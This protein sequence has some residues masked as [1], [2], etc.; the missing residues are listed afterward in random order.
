MQANNQ[1]IHAYTHICVVGILFDMLEGIGLDPT[2]QDIRRD[3]FWQSH[4]KIIPFGDTGG[5]WDHVRAYAESQWPRGREH[6][7]ARK[8]V[9]GDKAK[10]NKIIKLYKSALMSTVVSK[11]CCAV[12]RTEGHH[13][14]PMAAVPMKRYVQGEILSQGVL[15]TISEFAIQDHAICHHKGCRGNAAKKYKPKLSTLAS[16]LV[17]VTREAACRYTPMQTMELDSFGSYT[18]IG[19][20]HCNDQHWTCT[21]KFNDRWFYY[22]DLTGRRRPLAH[23]IN[24]TSYNHT[25]HGF[26]NAVYFY[27]K[28]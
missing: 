2:N 13:M 16:L 11:T 15:A 20:G 14:K 24:I 6:S 1:H 9:Y 3:N 21:F 25:P 23:V 12:C 5:V 18:L 7:A 26:K 22:D 19:I 17:L 10:F 28:V 4:M 27:T 8:T